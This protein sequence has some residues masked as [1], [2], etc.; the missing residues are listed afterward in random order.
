MLTADFHATAHGKIIRTNSKAWIRDGVADY[1]T[2]GFR[3]DDTTE[4]DALTL[5]L[6]EPN[7]VVLRDE[8]NEALRKL[9]KQEQVYATAHD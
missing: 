9:G 1:V 5:Y 4:L 7:L 3:F 2:I 6:S 8:L